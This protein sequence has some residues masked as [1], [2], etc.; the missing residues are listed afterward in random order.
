MHRVTTKT[1]GSG[2]QVCALNVERRKMHNPL[3]SQQSTPCQGL[4]RQAQIIALA[5]RLETFRTGT[6]DA[7]HERIGIRGHTVLVITS[8]RQGTERVTGHQAFQVVTECFAAVEEL[9]SLDL[10]VNGEQ[11]PNL[12][13]L[14]LECLPVLVEALF[15]TLLD[16][17]HGIGGRFDIQ[18]HPALS[19]VLPDLG[20]V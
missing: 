19:N 8:A 12:T 18:R 10:A 20:L 15:I 16:I 17:G 2:R 3:F 4:S 5:Q 9:Q 6:L 14:G 7:F 11:R 1:S 13:V